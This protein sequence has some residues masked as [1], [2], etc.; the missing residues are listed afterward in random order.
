MVDVSVLMCVFNTSAHMLK[1][2]I[3]SVLSQDYKNI[4]LV[5]VD[6]AST[7]IDTLKVLDKVRDNNRVVIIKNVE[8]KGLTKSLNIGLAKCRGKYVARLDSDD[9]AYPNRI[10]IEKKF[11]DKY[12]NYDIVCSYATYIGRK[13]KNFHKHV[14]YMSNPEKFNLKMLFMNVGPIHSTVMIRKKFLENNSV[15]YDERFYRSQDYKLWLDCLAC[16]AKFAWLQTESTIYR[17]HNKQISYTDS[18]DQERDKKKII[19]ENLERNLHI[20]NKSACIMSSIYSE[21]YEYPIQ[22]YI[23]AINICREKNR[24]IKKYDIKLFEKEMRIRW[25]HKVIKCFLKGK[26]ARGLLRLQTLYDFVN[27]GFWGLIMEKIAY[28]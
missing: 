12:T 25:I 1:D 2:S 9:M 4:E 27:G 24:N 16:G 15:E 17:F 13:P 8:N 7:N 20:D 10:A 23:S 18:N 21:K 22:E 26:D 3:K 28:R 19:V 6:D 11:L 5:I 14:N